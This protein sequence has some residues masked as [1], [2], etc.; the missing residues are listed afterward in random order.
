MTHPYTYVYIY[1]LY[2]YYICIHSHETCH[3]QCSNL[4]VCPSK[5]PKQ[6]IPN[7]M[8]K[9]GRPV[10]SAEITVAKVMTLGERAF[11]KGTKQQIT[12]SFKMD[13]LAM[14]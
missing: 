5:L 8:S 13:Q 7:P 2:K 14:I 3:L 4:W 9:L 1:V 12:D 10:T 11:L 6:H